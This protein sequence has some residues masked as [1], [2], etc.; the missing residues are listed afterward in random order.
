MKEAELATLRR[1][2]VPEESMINAKDNLANAYQQVGRFEEAHSMRRDL[3][4]E[5]LKH[6][7]EEHEMTLLAASNYAA[8]LVD[9]QRFEETRS[10]L[11]KTLPVARRVLGDSNRITLMMRWSYG[12]A[13][14]MDASATLDDLSEAVKTLEETTRIARRVLGGAHPN[15]KGIERNLR[16]ARA[17]LAAREGDVEPLREAMEAMTPE[18]A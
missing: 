4:S 3:Y 5:K 6:N 16:E 18:D 11:R 1:L 7:G 15:A 12:A 17:V 10:L 8:S 13:L 2:G 9:L 14:C